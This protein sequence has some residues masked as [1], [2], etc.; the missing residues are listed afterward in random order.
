MRIRFVD[1]TFFQRAVL[2]LAIAGLPVCTLPAAAQGGGFTPD[3]TRGPKDVPLSNHFSDKPSQP[4]AFAIPVEPL[5]YTAPGPLYLGQRNALAS[6]DFLDENHLLFTFRVPGLIHRQLQSG[7]TVEGDE[8]Q[9][10]AVVLALPLGNVQAEALWTLY[11][12][13]QYLW[14]LKN[15]HFLLRIAD[16][17]QQ[18]DATLDLKPLLRF[19]GP[20]LSM[21]MDPSQR[22]LVTNSH[23]PGKTPEKPG[24]VPTPAE[25]EAAMD[26]DA[27]QRPGQPEIIVR[28]LHRD[29]GQVMLVSRVRATVNLP[30]NVDGYLEALRGRGLDWVLN[31]NYFTGGSTVLGHV[32]STCAPQSEF[33]SQREILVTGCAPSGAHKLMALATNGRPLWQDLAAPEQIWPQLIRSP[34]GSRL[35]W[36][37]LAVSRAVTAYAPLDR[38]AIKG[39][40]VRI[41]DAATG[42]LALEAPASPI[43]DVGG[44]VAISPTGRRIAV[45]NAGSIQLYELPPAP[46]LPDSA[47][48]PSSGTALAPAPA[49]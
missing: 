48:A 21:Q 22:F 19:P 26:S 18:G 47:A 38:D 46:P 49:H 7:E 13:S 27:D 39:Q 29:S 3:H 14:M 32:D 41:F 24:R 11:D 44:N 28:I 9:I 30:I 10:R 35:G 37:T 43:L 12:R 6:L 25:A 36:E 17:V 2:C 20:V 33:I 1:L 8:R 45:L 15:G 31:L 23:E 16:T 4:P 5:G 34:D 42:K 40:V